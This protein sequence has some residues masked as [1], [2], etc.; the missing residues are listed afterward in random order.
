M[1]DLLGATHRCLS[2]ECPHILETP[3]RILDQY[4]ATAT[5]FASGQ[6]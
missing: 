1:E 2:P 5:G 6:K 3:L 4:G